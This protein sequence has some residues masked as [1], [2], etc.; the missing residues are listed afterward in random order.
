[1]KNFQELINVCKLIVA[2]STSFIFFNCN[3][4]NQNACQFRK[5]AAF[6][7]RFEIKIIQRTTLTVDFL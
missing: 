2:C 4:G 1:M 5:V 7:I 6:G 3:H